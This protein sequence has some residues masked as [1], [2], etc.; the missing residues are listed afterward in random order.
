MLHAPTSETKSERASSGLYNYSART[1][2]TFTSRGDS[3]RKCLRRFACPAAAPQFY[4][5]KS[6]S[7]LGYV[8]VLEYYCPNM[9]CLMPTTIG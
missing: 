3:Y 8:G 4:P 7:T 6:S 5:T 9:I 1:R 2:W